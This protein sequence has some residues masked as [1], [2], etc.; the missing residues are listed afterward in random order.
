MRFRVTPASVAALALTAVCT[1]FAIWQG[2][3]PYVPH[4]FWPVTFDTSTGR[5]IY[6]YR[7]ELPRGVHIAIGDNV[8]DVDHGD[9]V[10]GFRLYYPLAGDSIRVA[11]ANGIV[12]L[13]AR[14][15]YFPRPDGILEILRQVPGAIV[16]LATGLL[17]ARRPGIMTLALWLWAVSELGGPDLGR[18]L[19]WLPRSAMSAVAAIFTAL[20]FS[21]LALVSFAVR[22]PTGNVPARCRWL[23][24]A[25]WIASAGCAIWAVAVGWAA[26]PIPDSVSTVAFYWLS[27]ALEEVALLGVAGILLWKQ[28]HA[29][30]LEKPRI[31]WATTAFA[32][33]ALAQ[34][35]AAIY[36]FVY[37]HVADLEVA[38]NLW[39]AAAVTANVLPLLAMYPILRYRLIDVGFIID[40]AT[41]YSA[42]TLLAFATLA[43]VNWLAQ[44]FITD[45]L[46]A[47]VQ[48]MAAIA[49]GLGYFRVRGWVGHFIERFLF[50]DRFVA[51]ELLDKTIRALPYVGSRQAVDDTLVSE[52]PATLRLASAA[53]FRLDG[54]RFHRV[55]ATGWA[56][57]DMQSFPQ[58]GELLN[59]ILAEGP[60]IR[61]SGRYPGLHPLPGA[62]R[63]PALAV[64]V[65]RD[66]MLSAIVLYGRHANGTEI[67]PQERRLLGRLGDAAAVA[68]ETV[69]VAAL[70]RRVRELEAR[71]TLTATERG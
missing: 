53:L 39:R 66:R 68:Y 49:I 61:V 20:H 46:A 42:L 71:S 47:I 10:R 40:R 55:A 12:I 44:R 8:L 5:V 18:A 26:V 48:P 62:P 31:A 15:G 4:Q 58:N 25:A 11:T 43:G 28:A 23:D 65:I 63:D 56:D 51:E 13:H 37:Q 32:L 45:R 22:F 69:E 59:R 1:A 67:E 24:R 6:V 60:V 21:G 7:S 36:P 70:R 17:L 19:D 38:V 3:V 14:P 27:E 64:G 29:E 16:I 35:A 54:D 9:A 30:P 2:I 50:H 34:S 33:A 41:L 52:I 57:G